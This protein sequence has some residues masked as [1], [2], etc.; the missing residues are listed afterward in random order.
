[1]KK[2]LACGLMFWLGIHAHAAEETATTI[3]TNPT[4]IDERYEILND[5]TEI[6]DLKTTLIW[7]RCSVGQVWEESR[8]TGISK[9]LTFDEAQMLSNHEWRVPT[10]AELI[11][12][13]EPNPDARLRK[14]NKNAFPGTEGWFWTSETPEPDSL[15]GSFINFFNGYAMST[16]KKNTNHV[17]LIRTTP[18]K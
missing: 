16:L 9:E 10:P 11:T 8:C 2:L 14:L 12:L 13:F 17:Y 5:G 15:V 3:A 6:R 18:S 1:M 4:L 7:Q